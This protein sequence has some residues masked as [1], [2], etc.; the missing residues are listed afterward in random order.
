[1]RAEAENEVNGVTDT[2][3]EY[4]NKIRRRAYGLDPNTPNTTV[5]RTRT[6]FMGSKDDFRE[7]IIE[8]RAKELCFEGLRRMDL[9]R[10]NVLGEKIAQTAEQ[11]KQASASGSMREY[12]FT[13]ATN[14]V[15][16]KHELYPIPARERRENNTLTQNPGY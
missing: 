10:W 5:D 2:A 13:A 11:F 16:G 1:M 15:S 12:K 6:F 7:E 8:E 4:L 14:F 9:I 3:V